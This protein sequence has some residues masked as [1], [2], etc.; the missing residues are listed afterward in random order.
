M[1]RATLEFLGML[2]PQQTQIPISLDEGPPGFT[3]WHGGSAPPTESLVRPFDIVLRDGTF[4]EGV[5]VADV[6]WIVINKDDDIVWYRPWAQDEIDA[7]IGMLRMPT[8]LALNL[9]WV[10][11]EF[12]V[13]GLAILLVAY[14]FGARP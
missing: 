6:G 8:W 5:L 14:C 9:K 12:V 11:A 13:V 1:I 4:I 10:A 3:R 2:K 7:E